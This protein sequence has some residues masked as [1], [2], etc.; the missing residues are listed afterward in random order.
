MDLFL[1]LE[2]YGL[3]TFIYTYMKIIPVSILSIILEINIVFAQGLSAIIDPG[4]DPSNWAVVIFFERVQT[5]IPFIIVF[6]G[7]IF[8]YSLVLFLWKGKMGGKILVW[9]KRFMI[10]TLVAIFIMVFILSIIP[11]LKN[12]LGVGPQSAP[13]VPILV[14]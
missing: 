5:F 1:A 13:I 3:Y 11:F 7:T 4:E 6:T 14:E 8:F 2:W 10:S 9:S 12:K